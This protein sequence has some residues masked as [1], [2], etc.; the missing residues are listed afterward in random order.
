MKKYKNIEI[1][2]L[3]TFKRTTGLSKDNF[4]NLC[5]NYIL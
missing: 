1:D 3:E 2:T 5:Y 4:Q